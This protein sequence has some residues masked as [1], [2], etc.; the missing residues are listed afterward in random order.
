LPEPVLHKTGSFLWIYE[1]C[2][3]YI[4]FF[5][6]TV[7]SVKIFTQDISQKITFAPNSFH[8]APVYYT[9]RSRERPEQ[10]TEKERE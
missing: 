5:H 7:I 3:E 10:I 9:Q 6:K 1:K 2:D 8:T 4:K